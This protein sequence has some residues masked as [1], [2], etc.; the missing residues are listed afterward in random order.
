MVCRSLGRHAHIDF[1][2]SENAAACRGSDLQ[3]IANRMVPDASKPK[4][5]VSHDLHWR[6]TGMPIY[7][8]HGLLMLT[9][10]SP[11]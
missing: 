1:C 2:R 11:I 7:L 9:R 6:R 10:S 5:W 3:H 4:D 8:L